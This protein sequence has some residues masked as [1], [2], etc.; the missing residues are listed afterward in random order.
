MR[1]YVPPR[2]RRLQYEALES[3]E[4]MA[5]TATLGAGGVTNVISGVFRLRYGQ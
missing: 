4:L 1:K 5:V 3:R 2:S